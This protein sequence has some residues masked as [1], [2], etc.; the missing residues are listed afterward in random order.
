[1]QFF[2]VNGFPCPSLQN[3]ADHFLRTINKDFDEVC[4]EYLYKL[5]LYL[6]N[7]F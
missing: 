3:P 4:S 5:N 6:L 2:S 7:F 1:M